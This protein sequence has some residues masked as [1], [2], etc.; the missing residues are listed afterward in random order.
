MPSNAPAGFVRLQTFEHRL[1]LYIAIE[2]IA[3]FLPYDRFRPNGSATLVTND[4]ERHHV[5]ESADEIA[6]LITDA[7]TIAV[8]REHQ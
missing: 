4:G 3:R 8:A 5:S 1:P 6:H 7:N 2:E